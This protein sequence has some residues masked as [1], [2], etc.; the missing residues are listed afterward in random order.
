MGQSS[1][2]NASCVP[3]CACFKT[4]VHPKDGKPIFDARNIEDVEG[5]DIEKIER[6]AQQSKSQRSSAQ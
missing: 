3:C 4:K 5:L 1:N 2:G 6:Q